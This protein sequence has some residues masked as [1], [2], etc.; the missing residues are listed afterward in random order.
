MDPA[1]KRLKQFLGG[2]QVGDY[3]GL[4]RPESF[5]IAGISVQHI[6]CLETYCHDVL[7]FDRTGA[8]ARGRD[9]GLSQGNAL[10]ARKDACCD[11]TDIDCQVLGKHAAK[12]F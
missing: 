8:G 4:E 10:R 5:Q 2:V 12:L 6:H 9:G 1:K 7:A 3:P 11:G